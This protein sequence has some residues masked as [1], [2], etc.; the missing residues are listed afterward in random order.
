MT[1]ML[2]ARR[3]RPAKRSRSL[4]AFQEALSRRI[5]AAATVVQKD[6][7][8]G[9][10]IAGRDWLLALPDAGEV[11]PV[12]ALT[13]VPLTKPWLLGVA[14]VRGRVYAVTDLAAFFGEPTA[15]A[16]PQA[17]LL[18]V[19]Q[20]YERN[21]AILVERVLGLRN[22]ADLAPLPADGAAWSL[23]GFRDAQGVH[24]RELAL[25]RLLAAPEFSATAA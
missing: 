4:R 15:A 20:R 3:V 5:A 11:L 8:L 24:W 16:Q 7:R 6:L 17:R 25:P 12:P 21:A 9:V 22:I 23:A 13:P 1:T 10:R 18:L 19:G 2:G 14:T